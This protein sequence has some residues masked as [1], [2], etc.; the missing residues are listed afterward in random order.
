MQLVN[1][2]NISKTYFSKIEKSR[3]T[4]VAEKRGVN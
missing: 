4:H 2:K 3:N 1:R